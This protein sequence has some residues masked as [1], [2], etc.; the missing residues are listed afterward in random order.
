MHEE[1]SSLDKAFMILERLARKP[2]EMTALQLAKEL[3]I[4]RSTI[5]RIL[6]NLMERT[7]VVKDP[8]TRKYSVGPGAYRIGS[9]FL[10]KQPNIGSIKAELDK[11]AAKTKQ[12]IGYAALVQD[13]ILS[14]FEVESYQPIQIGYRVGVDYPIH[15]GAYG[16]CIMAFYE[17]Y[18]RLEEIVYSAKLTKN[19][20]NTITN[21]H[22]LLKEYEKIRENGYAISNEENVIGLVGIGVPIRNFQNKVVACVAAKYI[23]G[24]VDEEKQKVIIK[25][26]LEASERIEKLIT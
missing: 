15:C 21:P 2:Y 8:N 18:E 1:S 10:N 23:K 6:N 12:S 3:Q 7:V 14:I 20:P 16:K 13:R 25:H 22:D 24:N 17:P 9:G 19:T 11:L 4:N 26:L 5:H